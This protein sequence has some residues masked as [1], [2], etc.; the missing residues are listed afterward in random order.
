MRAILFIG[1][2]VCSVSL[3][4]SSRLKRSSIPVYLCHSLFTV[5]LILFFHRPSFVFPHLS[6]SQCPFQVVFFV[7]SGPLFFYDVY[8]SFKR[9]KL[10]LDNFTTHT[11]TKRLCKSVRINQHC[12]LEYFI[13]FGNVFERFV[14]VIH[15]F[16]NNGFK[17]NKTL[18]CKY[19]L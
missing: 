2:F 15:E 8:I 1:L 7:I 11:Q 6:L 13:T 16:L 18:K 10:F 14:H 3:R 19:S 4:P 17:Y 5:Y 9:H 12:L